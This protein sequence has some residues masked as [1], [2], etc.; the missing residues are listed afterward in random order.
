VIF[1]HYFAV[2]AHSGARNAITTTAHCGR[3]TK[4]QSHA[5]GC[6]N[7]PRVVKHAEVCWEIAL[8]AEGFQLDAHKHSVKI[9]IILCKVLLA[10]APITDEKDIQFW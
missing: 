3:A 4:C 5:T 2:R 8:A 1:L 7:L 9:A 6:G 10:V